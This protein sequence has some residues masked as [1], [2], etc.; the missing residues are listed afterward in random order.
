MNPQQCLKN[1]KS[2][3]EKNFFQRK[4][5]V[6]K[7]FDLKNWCE[8]EIEDNNEKICTRLSKTVSKKIDF[9][10]Y[11]FRR[12]RPPWRLKNLNGEMN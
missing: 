12:D 1:G 4:E 7:N 9:R 11:G 10:T 3:I 2:A 8:N 6:L 5:S